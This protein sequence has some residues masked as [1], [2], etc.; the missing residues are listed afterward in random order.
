MPTV[1]IV[2]DDRTHR[3]ILNMTLVRGGFSVRELDNGRTALETVKQ[4]HPDLVLVDIVMPGVS[5]LDTLQQLKGDEATR[6]LPVVMLTAVATPEHIQ[7]ALD[8]GAADYILKPFDP[9]LVLTV[10]RGLCS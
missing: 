6:A 2:D 3:Q 10:V 9:N 1:L 8:A 4:E 5:G 7:R